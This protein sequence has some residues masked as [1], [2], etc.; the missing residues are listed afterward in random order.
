MGLNILH[1]SAVAAVA[2]ATRPR[3]REAGA[4]PDEL[5]KPAALDPSLFGDAR[6]PRR[7]RRRASLV[8]KLAAA[9]SDA[10]GQ[11]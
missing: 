6:Y 2:L 11:T 5:S 4:F 10:A 9:S 1:P 8:N 3:R 7:A